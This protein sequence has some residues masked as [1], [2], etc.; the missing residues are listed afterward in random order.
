MQLAQGIYIK[1][2]QKGNQSVTQVGNEELSINHIP[3][4]WK[5]DV[6]DVDNFCRRTQR[7]MKL[8]EES[9]KYA[10]EQLRE[11]RSKLRGKLLS[12]FSIIDEMTCSWFITNS[13]RQEMSDFKDTIKLFMLAHGN[14]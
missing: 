8:I 2:C 11:R 13:V 1:D 12:K 10:L 9:L 4:L 6:V 5:S 14:Y 7:T 3:N